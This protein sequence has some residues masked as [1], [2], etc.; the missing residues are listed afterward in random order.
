MILSTVIGTVVVP[1]LQ[2]MSANFLERQLTELSDS[3]K[4]AITTIPRSFGD[5]LI[6]LYQAL[7]VLNSIAF[8]N[9][10]RQLTD[11]YLPFPPVTVINKS[12]E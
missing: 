6:R 1:T 5:Y 10:Q 4:K 9:N 7:N 8:S 11:Y 12:G 2:K 3:I